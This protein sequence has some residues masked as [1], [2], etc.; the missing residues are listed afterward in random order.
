MCKSCGEELSESAPITDK[1]GLDQIP[2]ELIQH[3]GD[4]LMLDIMHSSD[5]AKDAIAACR[6][7]YDSRG[8]IKGGGIRIGASKDK[9]ELSW[10]D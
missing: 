1:P 6:L 10:S 3:E 2:T 7:L 4:K 9:I 5:D 8:L